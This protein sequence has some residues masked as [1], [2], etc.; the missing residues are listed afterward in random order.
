MKQKP[1]QNV[2]LIDLFD[3]LKREVLLTLNC[4]AIGEITKF[5]K[6]TQLAEVKVSYDRKKL[7]ANSNGDIEEVAVPYPALSDVPVIF[8]R[9]KSG[10]AGLSFPVE[11][12]DECILLFNDRD[13]DNWFEGKKD[14]V[15][16]SSRLHSMSDAIALVGV[17]S[18][19][20]FIQDFDNQ[21]ASL[22]FGST[23][24]AVGESKVLIENSS[25]TLNSLL[26]ELI[27]ELQGLTTVGSATT[28]TIS[29]GNIANLTAIGTKIGE[30]L[31]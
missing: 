16:R 4:H 3:Q 31:E 9:G 23:R 5:D 8:L 18:K 13:I 25:H 7:Q 11:S 24:V 21:R 26:Q 19:D 1:V 10:D 14:G 2:D 12:G 27:T 28:Q 15:V 29:P 6:D 30:L 20:N 17:S 22:F